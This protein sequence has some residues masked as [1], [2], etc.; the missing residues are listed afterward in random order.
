MAR[1]GTAALSTAIQATNWMLD[2]LHPIPVMVIFLATPPL[3][4][5]TMLQIVAVAP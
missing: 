2:N 5:L 1:I 4:V 3:T